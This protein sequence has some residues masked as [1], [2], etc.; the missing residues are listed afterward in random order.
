MIPVAGWKNVHAASAGENEEALMEIYSLIEEGEEAGTEASAGALEDLMNLLGNPSEIL[1]KIREILGNPS[2]LLDKLV[3]MLG[4]SEEMLEMLKG[5]LKDPEKL[6]AAIKSMIEMVLDMDALH[7]ADLEAIRPEPGVSYAPAALIKSPEGEKFTVERVVYVE[8]GE[9]SEEERSFSPYEA[10]QIR[11]TLLANEDTRFGGASLMFSYISNSVDSKVEKTERGLTGGGS[12]AY[13]LINMRARKLTGPVAAVNLTAEA[14]LSGQN[15]N[16]FELYLEMPEED[17]YEQSGG[18]WCGKNGE[19]L[20]DVETFVAGK[21]Y[22]FCCY[23]SADEGSYF[24]EETALNVRGATVS[25]GLVIEEEDEEHMHAYVILAVKAE[26]APEGLISNVSLQFTLPEINQK[27]TQKGEASLTPELSLSIPEEATYTFSNPS[28]PAWFFESY[29]MDTPKTGTF[30]IANE[31][32][33]FCCTELK[34]NTPG[35][36]FKRAKVEIDGE[37]VMIQRIELLDGTTMR[38]FFDFCNAQYLHLSVSD[39]GSHVGTGG[40]IRYATVSSSGMEQEEGVVEEEYSVEKAPD[41]YSLR[42][43][44]EPLDGYTFKGWYPGTPD[45]YE[46]EENPIPAYSEELISSDPVLTYQSTWDG[47]KYY[48]AVFESN[49][50]T[51]TLDKTSAKLLSGKTL[52]LTATKTPANAAITWKSSDKTIATVSKSGLVTAKLPGTATIT[53]TT[54]KGAKATCKVK[55]TFRTVYQCAKDGVYRYTTSTK[56][57]KELK[58]A[59]WTCMKKFHAPGT[60]KT[61]VYWVYNKTA[62]R[63][64][65][66]TNLTYAKKMKADGNKYGGA[67]YSDPAKSVP[68]YELRKGTG[69]FYTAKKSIVESMKKKGWTYV[70]IAWYGL[71]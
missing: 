36:F 25:G 44:A 4:G 47:D 45:W 42:L 11:V 35:Q 33:Y 67:F 69:Y 12:R 62:K 20:E 17:S 15:D 23:L 65:W 49:A 53:A 64:R 51:V 63:Y 1:A 71:P 14:P 2:D 40:R 66:T 68:V 21:T 57:M 24:T 48:C 41:G 13:L 6:V 5:Y 9:E 27:F 59:G 19:Y 32:A 28:H 3:K 70:H 58:A 61:R 38:V 10:F 54:D 43:T 16:D 29:E 60:S 22:Y 31:Q 7:S 8:D 34:A 46:D 18:N 37:G 56:T 39:T 55:V 50:G 30:S 52:Q 26:K